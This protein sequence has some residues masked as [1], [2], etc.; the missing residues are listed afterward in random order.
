MRCVFWHY[1]IFMTNEKCESAF[2]GKSFSHFEDIKEKIIC[3]NRAPV[4]RHC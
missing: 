3:P 1:Q 4:L 2:G